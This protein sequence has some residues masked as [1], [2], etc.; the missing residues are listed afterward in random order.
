Q[1]RQ[2]RRTAGSGFSS[3]SGISC[4]QL[5][6][7][8]GTRFTAATRINAEAE[9]WIGLNR[10]FLARLIS[11]ELLQLCPKQTDDIVGSYHSGQHA[12]VIHDWKR[13]QIIFV[14]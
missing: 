2:Q 6:E 11:R 10:R 12:V 5:S 1:D 3:V 9:I 7:I 4:A 8:I 14:E 13:K